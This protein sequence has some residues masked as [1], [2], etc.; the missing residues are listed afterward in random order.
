M[1]CL[2]CATVV[3]QL[4]K[5]P[6]KFCSHQCWSVYNNRCKICESCGKTSKEVSFRR[7]EKK[8]LVCRK[9]TKRLPEM[10]QAKLNQEL[11]RK[12]WRPKNEHN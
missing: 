5:K 6:A 7:H 9:K 1:N 2:E 12:F 11:M 8:C 3:P 4:G 10:E